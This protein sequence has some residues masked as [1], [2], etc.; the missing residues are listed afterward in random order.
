MSFWSIVLPPSSPCLSANLVKPL[1]GDRYLVRASSSDVPDFLSAD[2]YN[3]SS[4]NCFFFFFQISLIG[5]I[6]FDY[7]ICFYRLESRRKRPFGPRLDVM[8][9]L[10]NLDLSLSLCYSVVLIPLLRLFCNSI[11]RKM[12]FNTSLMH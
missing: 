5:N 4:L 12:L 10:S 7:I 11:V 8:I 1:N 6:L 3:Y 9:L 2:W